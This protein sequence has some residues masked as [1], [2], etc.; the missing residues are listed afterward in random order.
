MK[1]RGTIV[2]FMLIVCISALLMFG[3][4][5][6]GHSW[7]DDFSGYIMQARSITEGTPRAFV[8]SNRFS[9]EQ[10]SK[11]IGPTAYPWGFPVLLA[12]F[13]ALFGLNPLALKA[14]GVI[15][16]LLFLV[17]LWL[18]FHRDHSTPWFFCF[19]CLFAFNPT[20]LAFSNHILS[21]LPF[22][23]VSTVSVS[24]IRDIVVNDRRFI[25][26]LWDL[27]LL[28]IG[29][30]SASLIRTN[31]YLLVITLGLSHLVSYLQKHPCNEQP[32]GRGE[33][34]HPWGRSF[35]PRGVSVKQT[36]LLLAPYI[37]FLSSVTIWELFFPAGGASH[38]SHLK[39]ISLRMIIKHLA[40][41]LYLPSEF[42]S[43][44]PYRVLL[45]G[46]SIPFAVAGAV[47]RYRSDYPAII[48]MAL[49]LLLYIFWPYG[50]KKQGLRFLFPI[51]PFYVSFACSGLEAFGD[52][53]TAVKGV[54]RKVLSYA[55]VVL[56][57]LLFVRTDVRAVYWNYL[58]HGE[59]ASGPFAPTSQ[60]MFSF[61]V[62]HTEADSIVVF[63]KPRV[64]RLMTGRQSIMIDRAEQLS[65]GDYLCL[66]L[67]EDAYNQV[68]DGDVERL[69]VREAA[70]IV[71]KNDDFKVYRMIKTR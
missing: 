55:P 71:Y 53:M 34:H 24:L 30:A 25:S 33:A 10:S 17:V 38:V 47:R 21:D 68:S 1:Q 6:R 20:L 7:G 18:A 19:V 23:V 35:F 62:N 45:Y 59:I 37:V 5:T 15:S 52:G 16:Y 60:E 57:V 9:V 26:R 67:R 2:I 28:G 51:L 64:M 56:V 58:T 36:A 14:V 22:L 54:I 63:F 40:Y 3:M 32:H 27:I 61:V 4:L 11:P 13:Y 29:M 48:Y 31:G 12:P 69:L 46:A 43:G 42:F 41:Y 50:Q 66:Y 49:T 70:Q 8:E 39:S 44:A 65:R